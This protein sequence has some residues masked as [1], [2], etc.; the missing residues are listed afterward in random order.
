MMMMMTM[1]WQRPNSGEWKKLKFFFD[2]TIQLEV[3]GSL[4]NLIFDEF[5]HTKEINPIFI[6]TIQTQSE[7]KCGEKVSFKCKLISREL[8][9]FIALSEWCHFKHFITFIDNEQ[10]FFHSSSLFTR[11]E[12]SRTK[13][14]RSW[15]Y[16]RYEIA[17]M[18]R[19]CQKVAINESFYG[20]IDRTVWPAK[21]HK[22]CELGIVVESPIQMWA[23][24][25][26]FSGDFSRDN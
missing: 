12:F 19:K 15:H 11:S 8:L 17:E 9:I 25:E 22:L 4:L 16:V 7:K 5:H 10:R 13:A 2:A 23:V 1:K 14:R 6:W 20:F 3:R 24:V 18:D 26:I 21:R